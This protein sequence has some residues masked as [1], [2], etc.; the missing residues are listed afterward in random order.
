MRP[1]QEVQPICRA[2]D[3]F[4]FPSTTDT[5]AI[6]VCE[7]LCA[8]LP[9]VAVR[10]GGTPEVVREG[11]DGFLTADSAEEFTAR[12]EQLLTDDRLR[13]RMAEEAG[14]GAGRFSEASMADSFIRFYERVIGERRP[15]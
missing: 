4:A 7:A 2:G 6:V 11:V 9:C 5:Q 15:A 10:E 3:L 12:I 8:G 14:S 1:R 13:R